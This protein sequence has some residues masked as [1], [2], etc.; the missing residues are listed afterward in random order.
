[1][2]AAALVLGALAWLL[3]FANWPRREVAQLQ[4]TL[5]GGAPVLLTLLIADPVIELPFSGH[6][7]WVR[8]NGRSWKLHGR[9]FGYGNGRIAVSPDGTQAVVYRSFEGGESPA[10]LIDLRT[11]K[12]QP[13]SR[14]TVDNSEGW[15]MHEYESMGWKMHNWQ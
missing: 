11:L 1:L 2:A 6:S 8:C 5:P 13:A 15:R 12:M 3:F 9:A 14:W 4:L 10:V 7:A